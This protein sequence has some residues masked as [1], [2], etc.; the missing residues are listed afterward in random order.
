MRP[1]KLLI[2]FLLF[3]FSLSAQTH[4]N[5]LTI[6]GGIEHGKTPYEYLNAYGPALQFD[7]S[8]S[9]R[10]TLSAGLG[11]IRGAFVSKGTISGTDENGDYFSNSFQYTQKEQFSH[12]DATMLYTL[13]GKDSRNQF[14][15][16][17]GGL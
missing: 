16:G 9:D 8:L 5:T 17:A 12:L 15:I 4:Q 13:F 10:W 6:K 1:T 3:A 11:H 14:K 2:P 7:Y